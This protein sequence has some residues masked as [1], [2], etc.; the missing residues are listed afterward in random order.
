MAAVTFA[1]GVTGAVAPVQIYTSYDV[2]VATEPQVKVADVCV[3]MVEAF[4]GAELVAHTGTGIAAVV[5]VVLFVASQPAAGP[6]AFF[7]TTYQLYRVD[8]VKPVAA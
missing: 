5:N 7:G 4:A 3:P 1:V 2:A 8:A 6:D